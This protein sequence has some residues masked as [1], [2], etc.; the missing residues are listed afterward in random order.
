MCGYMHDLNHTAANTGDKEGTY[1][2]QGGIFQDP[3]EAAIQNT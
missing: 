2:L 3:K 1:D